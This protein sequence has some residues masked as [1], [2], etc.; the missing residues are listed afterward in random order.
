MNKPSSGYVLLDK[1]DVNSIRQEDLRNNIGVV[2]QNVE[3]FSGTLEDNIKINAED[4]S[5]DNF[6]AAA[7]LSGVD[8]FAGQLQNAYKLHLQEGG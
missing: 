4:V 1:V 7:R 8:E 2:L 6:F 3:L 5:N